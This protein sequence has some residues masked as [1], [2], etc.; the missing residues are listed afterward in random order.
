MV[1]I[2]GGFVA[3]SSDH[4]VLGFKVNEDNSSHYGYKATK[5]YE[6]NYQNLRPEVYEHV[7]P[8]IAYDHATDNLYLIYPQ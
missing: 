5:V 3:V 1:H 4:R 7:I 8:Q 6:E 2:K